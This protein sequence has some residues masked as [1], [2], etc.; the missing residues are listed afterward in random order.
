MRGTGLWLGRNLRHGTCDSGSAYIP[1][2]SMVIAMLRRNSVG[3]IKIVVW[4]AIY[5]VCFR[6]LYK[7]PYLSERRT[8]LSSYVMVDHT[9]SL[10]GHDYLVENKATMSSK[11]KLHCKFE[12]F[13]HGGTFE[14]SPKQHQKAL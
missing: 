10:G 5:A 13:W 3:D 4:E 2:Q 1:M 9:I 14:K 6:S 7:S 11:R 8:S 12:K